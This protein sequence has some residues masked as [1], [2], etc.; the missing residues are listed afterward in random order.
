MFYTSNTAEEGMKR[1]KLIKHLEFTKMHT[2]AHSLSR[3][4]KLKF[5]IQINSGL[6]VNKKLLWE[7]PSLIHN[8]IFACYIF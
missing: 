1:E 7:N 8:R 4:N 5:Q 6:L 3:R 2:C